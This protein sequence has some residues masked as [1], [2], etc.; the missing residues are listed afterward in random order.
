MAT[1]RDTP[2]ETPPYVEHQGAHSQYIRDIILGVNDGPDNFGPI[3]EQCASGQLE[4]HI[5]R[6]Y[7]LEGVA[8]AIARVGEGRALGKIV[9]EPGRR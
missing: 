3:G 1:V 7:G 9:V 5:D 6:T 4:V 8:E 2:E